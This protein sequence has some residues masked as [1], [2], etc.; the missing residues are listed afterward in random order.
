MNKRISGLLMGVVFILLP[1][2]AFAAT[3]EEINQGSVD[4]AKA[5]ASTKPTVEMVMERVN[6]GVELMNKEGRNAFNKFKGADSEFIYAG[7]YIWI[8]SP[9]TGEM[10]MHPMKT[11]LEGKNVNPLRDA[12]GKLLFVEFNRVATEQGSGWVNYMWPKPGEK[13][14]SMKVSFVKLAEHNGEKF[15][16]GSGVYDITLE[17]INKALGK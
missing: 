2:M 17:E 8:H 4:R 13:K 5:T 12:D 14:P 16:V 3:V 9:T 6:A 10:L 15:V 1:A 11:K 7:T